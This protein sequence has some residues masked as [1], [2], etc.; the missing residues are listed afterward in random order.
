[1]DSE[2]ASVIG[3]SLSFSPVR[4]R[5]TAWC[6]GRR[7]DPA[8]PGRESGR[9][10]CIDA[11]SAETFPGPRP[12]HPP[13][14]RAR[15]SGPGCH[16]Q[17]RVGLGPDRPPPEHSDADG[18]R[19]TQHDRRH[20]NQQPRPRHQRKAGH[21]GGRDAR[22][23]RGITP[24]PQQRRVRPDEVDRV[25]GA[26]IEQADRQVTAVAVG[27][28]RDDAA[29]LE[30]PAQGLRIEYPVQ[31]QRPIAQSSTPGA[32]RALTALRK[33]S[34]LAPTSL[35][36]AGAAE[37]GRLRRAS[38]PGTLTTSAASASTS[39]SLGKDCCCVVS[40]VEERLECVV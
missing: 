40:T 10:K 9:A 31:H 14:P 30:S 38:A 16:R 37:S 33:W 34:R 36:H 8:T 5:T 19:R 6:A 21:A 22:D 20:A 24:P 27:S 1:M 29:A 17:G 7:A 28:H 26:V 35:A 15:S 2:S 4:D 25:S 32:A 12:L 23:P 18:Q 13:Q 39:G 3:S 11:M